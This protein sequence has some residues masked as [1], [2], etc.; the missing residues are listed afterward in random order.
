MGRALRCHTLG[1]ASPLADV[2]GAHLLLFFFLLVCIHTGAFRWKFRARRMSKR[3]LRRK[4]VTCPALFTRMALRQKRLE[5]CLESMLRSE[6]LTVLLGSVMAS[7]ALTSCRV[8]YRWSYIR[9][10]CLSTRQAAIIL[11]CMCCRL[12]GMHCGTL[13]WCRTVSAVI[14]CSSFYP[15][16][17]WCCLGI[18]C[19]WLYPL[20]PPTTWSGG[21]RTPGSVPPTKK[22]GSLLQV[23]DM[24]TSSAQGSVA[25]DLGDVH[26][27]SL[28]VSTRPYMVA[29]Q[30]D[31]PVPSDIKHRL[32]AVLFCSQDQWERCVRFA[33][34]LRSGFPRS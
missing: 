25:A 1:S 34:S 29:W 6:V 31:D 3:S 32:T 19:G 8:F 2:C 12:A 9:P 28:I 16:W 13:F 18:V 15:R 22:S 30:T 4:M 24:T 21:E 7:I 23:G 26:K 5:A 17:E 33:L 20:F 27:D 10:L 11:C 14:Y